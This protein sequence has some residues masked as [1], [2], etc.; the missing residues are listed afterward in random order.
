M[1]I[2][3]FQRTSRKVI[4][5]AVLF[6]IGY[7]VY[8]Y[9][10][11]YSGLP[12]KQKFHKQTIKLKED[13]TIFFNYDPKLNT[14][15]DESKVKEVTIDGKKDGVYYF[16]GYGPLNKAFNSAGLQKARRLEYANVI[17][18]YKYGKELDKIISELNEYQRYNHF[19]CLGYLTHKGKLWKAY[20]KMREKFS[21]D[22]HFMPESYLLPEDKD[23]L[24][25]DFDKHKLWIVKPKNLS[26]GRGIKVINNVKDIPKE[27]IASEY[28]MPHLI[29]GKK[30][31][32]RITCLVTSIEPL[33]IYLYTS[34][35]IV[36]FS[37]HKYLN[38]EE[39]LEDNFMH[40]TNKSINVKSTKW[41]ENKDVN[42]L[43][44][45]IASLRSYKNYC[46]KN[47][48]CDDVFN[49]IKDYVIKAILSNIDEAIEQYKKY[50]IPSS[51][52]VYEV[53]GVD[54]MLDDKLNPYLIE[55][56]LSPDWDFECKVS[57]IIYDRI[58]CDTLNLIGIKS[59]DHKNT[60]R[61][62][63]NFDERLQENFDELKRERGGW[64]LI[65]PLK[66]NIDKYKKFI[67]KPSEL[68]L[69]LWN[70]IQNQ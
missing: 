27:G 33:K 44:P 38:D 43:Q 10:D 39:F 15:L 66:E 52:N 2:S 16:R 3:I 28:I 11:L 70:G 31:D 62:I 12:L 50:N 26:R 5:C 4:L 36:R 8:N 48:N 55:M 14:P 42:K 30:Y 18:K 13:G 41:Q 64:E 65:F 69:A 35:G 1:S 47:I 29:F 61:R 22:Y 51:R 37:S 49:K 54:I 23:R 21:D 24:V 56:N 19:P 59:Y 58:A 63:L 20:S 45:N 57:E 7:Y 32:F 53:F 68:D 25:R 34:D 6:C 40:L 67:D 17:Y 60:K 9:N 46:A